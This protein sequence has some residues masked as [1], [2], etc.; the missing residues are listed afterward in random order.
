LKKVERLR[1]IGKDFDAKMT[2]LLNPEQHQKFQTL[3]EQMRRQ[4]I[5][6]VV[7]DAVQKLESEV[8]SW[9]TR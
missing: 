2:P 6:T 7:G 5:E 9:Y 8:K 4:I 1:E 3:R